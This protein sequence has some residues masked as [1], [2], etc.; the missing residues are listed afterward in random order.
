[1]TLCPGCQKEVQA[2]RASCPHCFN[3]LSPTVTQPHFQQAPMGNSP[4]QAP[5]GN[6]PQQA[7]MGNYPQQA[8]MGNSP[9]QAPMGNYPQQAPMGNYPQQ[10]PMGNYPQQAPMGNYPQQAPVDNGLSIQLVNKRFFPTIKLTV[11]L[12]DS[13]HGIN[14]EITFG[15]MARTYKAKLANGTQIGKLPL[16]GVTVFSGA[17][18]V[19][20]FPSGQKY[21]VLL[22]TSIAGP[23]GM[24]ITDLY[25]GRMNMIY[26]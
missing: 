9:Q 2:D 26:F 18:G 16:Q 24:T 22:P 1:M 25:D 17:R 11:I 21:D 19:I 13:L 14:E 10:A 7:P 6:S 20:L 3:L 12:R 15:T 8:P 5:M 23:T 4:Q